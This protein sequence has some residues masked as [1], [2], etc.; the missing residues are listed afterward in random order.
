MKIPPFL[1]TDE[2]TIEAYQGEGTYGTSFAG[3]ETVRCRRE[4]R[5]RV[6]VGPQGADVNVQAT[7][8]LDPGIEVPVESRATLDG[9]TYS[10]ISSRLHTDLTGGQ[11]REVELA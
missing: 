11:Y 3:A 7:L 9:Q 4:S 6:A 8:F 2:V 10:V 5:K 1:L